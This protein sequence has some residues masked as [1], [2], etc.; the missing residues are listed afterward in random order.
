MKIS[1][2]T[3]EGEHFLM[4]ALQQSDNIAV[5]SVG[6]MAPIWSTQT[7][8]TPYVFDGEKT[9]KDWTKLLGTVVSK[10]ESPSHFQG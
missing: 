6:Y 5:S 8:C 1:L 9:W 2:M 3:A 4:P 10:I 7:N